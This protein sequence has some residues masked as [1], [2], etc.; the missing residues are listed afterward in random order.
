M[1]DE[2]GVHEAEKWVKENGEDKASFYPWLETTERR[3][4]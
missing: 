3:G 2:K 4:E 1:A